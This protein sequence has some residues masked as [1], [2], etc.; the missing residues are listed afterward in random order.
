MAA[1]AVNVGAPVLVPRRCSDPTTWQLLHHFSASWWPAAASPISCAIAPTDETF[2]NAK[3]DSHA[4]I[5]T[6]LVK[7]ALSRIIGSSHRF[8]ATERRR[9]KNNI[10]VDQAGLWRACQTGDSIDPGQDAAMKTC[11]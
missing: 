7:I 1:I 5:A 9:L 4:A 2:G 10:D 8:E 3:Q 11:P 6:V